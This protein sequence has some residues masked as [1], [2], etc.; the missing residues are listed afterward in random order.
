MYYEID[1]NILP[2]IR[3]VDTAVLEPPYIHRR[4]KPGEFI[5]YIMKSGVLYLREEKREYVLRKGDVLLLDADFEHEG[6][7]ASECE[8]FYIHFQHPA[9]VRMEETEGFMEELLKKRSKSLQQDSASWEVYGDSSMFFPKY[10]TLRDDGNYLRIVQL[11]QEAIEHNRNQ[12]E[13][14]KQICAG[15]IME[16][17][18]EISRESLSAWS[19]KQTNSVVPASYQKVHELLSYLNENFQKHI[20]GESIEEELSCNFDYLNRVFKKST[21][22]TIFVYLNEIRLHHAMEL[23]TTT[24]M[25]ISAVSYRVGFHDEGY[26]SKA[27]R[28]YTGLSPGKYGKTAGTKRMPPPNLTVRSYGFCSPFSGTPAEEICD[29]TEKFIHGESNPASG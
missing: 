3:L 20:S 17:L 29:S 1:S 22:K 13:Y 28:K 14:Y 21:G 7:K 18:A 15:R 23:L 5:L 2:Q 6:K 25:K 12:L 10:V 8:Y 11:I 19:M 24:S 27:F 26:F 16:V 9:M 4:R